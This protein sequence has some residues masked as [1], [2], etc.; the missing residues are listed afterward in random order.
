MEAQAG[1]DAD[2]HL[3][4]LVYQALLHR[5]YRVPVHSILLY[6]HPK[7]ELSIQTGSIEYAVWKDL[8]KMEFEYE[9][10]RLW[11]RPVDSF[12]LGPLS[13]LPLAPL[14]RLPEELSLEEG[15]RWVVNR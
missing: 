11:E 4:L 6:L 9:V 10:V 8:G 7:A 1:P 2:K 15:L 14:C 12:L 3:D 13:T 5:K